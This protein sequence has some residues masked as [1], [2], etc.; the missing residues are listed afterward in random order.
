MKSTFT[1]GRLAGV[2][3][4]FNWSWLIVV[5]LVGWSLA[6]AVFP[7][8]SPGL[9]DTTY[10]IMAVIAVPA[11]FACLLL[12]ELGHATQ[13]RREGMEIDGI[14]LWVFGG[15]ARFRG[16]LPSA[17]AEFR[18]AIAGP[19]VTLALAAVF[20]AVSLAAP[21]PAAMDGVVGWLA[22]V[23]LL[24][25]GFNLV[26]A[27]PLDGGRV[28][29]AALWQAKGDYAAATRTA[30]ALGRLFGQLLITGGV[31]LVFL[32]GTLGGLW[33]A[34]IGW[35]LLLAAEAEAQ[36]A[37]AHVALSGL[38]VRDAMVAA[39]VT[40]EADLS[41]ERFM[42]EVFL[43]HRFT[44]Y[45]VVD[46]GVPVGL[47]T[48][49]DAAAVPRPHWPGVV[50]RDRMTP[51]AGVVVVGPDDP[52]EAAWTA[53]L[54]SPIRRALVLGGGLPPGLLSA[55]DVLRI[56]EARSNGTP[57]RSGRPARRVTA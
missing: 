43:A 47:V 11:F 31:F 4:G 20:V 35:F 10:A 57:G 17:G 48:Y 21:L 34:L 30:A 38:R 37:V 50:V 22:T 5:A 51:L 14:T 40:V 54:G 2:E 15:V 9:S 39:P 7:D 44:A 55:T 53:L 32:T 41:V 8:S 6:G 33:L 19:L 29:R 36:A 42:D 56:L 24:L 45:P 12:H 28:L 27:L 18:I 25:L 16:I 1:L 23:N 13:A 52:L 3:V 46:G 49:R 26:P